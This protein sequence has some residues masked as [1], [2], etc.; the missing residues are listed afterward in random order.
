MV[1]LIATRRPLD[2]AIT[3]EAP[4]LTSAYATPTTAGW[5][6]RLR[7]TRTQW[8]LSATL[9]A[10]FSGRARI[11]VWRTTRAARGVDLHMATLLA[12]CSPVASLGKKAT[13]LTQ[14]DRQE[15]TEA[16]RHVYIS[17][18]PGFLASQRPPRGAVRGGGRD[19]PRREATPSTRSDLRKSARR[20]PPARGSPRSPGSSRRWG[21]ARA[22]RVLRPARGPRWA[23]SRCR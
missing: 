5:E 7:A 15:G 21:T 3:V 8:P 13:V 19:D 12:R 22:R 16:D 17:T 11:P 20:R 4:L 23:C 14:G 9:G 2:V 10:A 1:A 18:P 6:P